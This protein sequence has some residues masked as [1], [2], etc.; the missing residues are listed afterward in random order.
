MKRVEASRITIPIQSILLV[1][2]IVRPQAVAFRSKSTPGHLVHVVESGEVRQITDG[3]HEAFQ[4]GNVVWYH[5]TELIEGRIVRAPWRFITINF[6]A[7]NLAPPRDAQRVLP[8]GPQTLG[9]ARQLLT[10]WRNKAMPPVERELRSMATLGLL[11]LDFLPVAELPPT[12]DGYPFTARD[13]WWEAEK[14]LRSRLDTHMDI[15][16]LAALA[17]MTERAM[18]RACKTATGMSPAQRLREL[19]M[20]LAQN[21]L[22]HSDLRITEVAMKV[23]YDRV[24]E[25]S[26]A[27]KQHH[28]C[29]PRDMR[30]RPP[31]Y[32]RMHRGET[33]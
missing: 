3:R 12:T 23:G 26:R 31:V 7:P 13:R 2:E 10:L 6:V 32:R 18:V 33:V 25:F 22:Q 8:G 24:Q 27:F 30:S 19:R 16:A 15:E 5:E 28:G 14:R 1:D 9:L 29:T 17:G 4:E 21:L 11:L 20:V